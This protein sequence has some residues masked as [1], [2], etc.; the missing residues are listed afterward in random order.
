MCIAVYEAVLVYHLSE[1]IDQ[2]VGHFLRVDTCLFDLLPVVDLAASHEFHND[3]SLRGKFCVVMW[4]IDM[5][6]I[7]EI[8]FSLQGIPYFNV[9]IQLFN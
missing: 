6:V 7:F 1:D 3:Y 5:R 8:L 9:K 2:I 4:D